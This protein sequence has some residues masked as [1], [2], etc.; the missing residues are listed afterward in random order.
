MK[1]LV[2]SDVTGL[3]NTCDFVSHVTVVTG[4]YNSFYI[5][6]SFTCTSENVVYCVICSKC[7]H[8]YIGETGPR[9]G[10]RF[11]EHHQI[12]KGGSNGLMGGVQYIILTRTT[13]LAY[14]DAK[15]CTLNL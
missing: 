14:L 8:S 4:A 10:D 6:R 9:L 15:E 12:L 11:R 5:R 7:G 1:Y 2:P 13:N 3:C